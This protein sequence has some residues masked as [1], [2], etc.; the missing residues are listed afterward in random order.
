MLALIAVIGALLWTNS[1]DDDDD[2]FDDDKNDEYLNGVY[3]FWSA[4]V[5]SDDGRIV[6]G[7]WN[8]TLETVTDEKVILFIGQPTGLA[9][10]YKYASLVWTDTSLGGI[11]SANAAT[12]CAYN[13]D[14]DDYSTGVSSLVS[15]LTHPKRIDISLGSSEDDGPHMYWTDPYDGALYRSTLKGKHKEALV[16]GHPSISGVACTEEKVYF[17]VPATQSIYSVSFQGKDKT[18]VSTDVC[19][20]PQDLVYSYELKKM[21]VSCTESMVDLEGGLL[22]SGLTASSLNTAAY[23]A[24]ISGMFFNVFNHSEVYLIPKDDLTAHDDD[25]TSSLAVLKP[26]LTDIGSYTFDSHPRGIAVY[27]ARNI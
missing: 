12:G 24:T 16:T 6:R 15:G 1:S 7:W 4:G 17:T 9:I 26:D 2:D 19:E 22:L 3:V 18:L 14:D 13:C 25:G 11:F 23:S 8:S 20:D 5:S 27:D 10:N 21:T